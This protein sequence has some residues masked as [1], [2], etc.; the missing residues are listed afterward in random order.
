MQDINAVATDLSK[1]NP[2]NKKATVWSRFMANGEH[3]ASIGEVYKKTA[4][5]C[6]ML[7]L[8]MKKHEKIE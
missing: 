2:V 8:S 6:E 1:M 7:Y 5:Y 4:D 3:R